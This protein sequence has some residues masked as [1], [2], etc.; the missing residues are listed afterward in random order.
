MAAGESSIRRPRPQ[1]RAAR[2]WRVRLAC[3]LSLAVATVA[4]LS[5]SNPLGPPN[6]VLISIDTLRADHLGAYGYSRP[7]SPNIDG[8]AR[9]GA[10]FENAYSPASWTLPAHASMM[11]GVSP[12]RHG[13]VSPTTRIRTDF[14]TLAERLKAGGYATAAAINAP[15]VSKRYGFDRGFDTFFEHYK[16]PRN[17]VLYHKRVLDL[18]A[19]QKKRPVFLFIH[20]MDV[21][22]PYRPPAAFNRFAS[23]EEG[24][25]EILHS[26]GLRGANLLEL[27]R[28]VESGKTALT[29][30]ER[31]T[32]VGLYDGEILSI[33]SKI[34]EVVAAIR[35]ELGDNTIIIVTA[36]HGEEFLEHGGLLH[37][38]TLYDEVLHV[39]LIV[40]GPGVKP[41]T[42]LKSMV[43]L[44][45][46]LPTVVEWT[47]IAT[48]SAV[49][50][51]SFLDLMRGR[52]SD[53]NRPNE[54]ALHTR[55][56][57]QSVDLRGLRL[58]NAKLIRDVRKKT[59]AS[60]DL[61]SDPGEHDPKKALP[62][63]SATELAGLE[64]ELNRLEV[65]AS[66]PPPPPDGDV[67]ESLRAL[68]YL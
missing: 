19:T 31:E 44:L 51:R 57:D 66:S 34:A 67:V 3:G 42:R 8:L 41:G 46:I 26:R 45:D 49:E 25:D 40:V 2:P 21:H 58:A 38:T 22:S 64:A 48:D 33:D 62:D 43:S 32:L 47:K 68:G 4:L 59:E 6:V 36:D 15:F 30:T 14:S 35:Q 17:P 20:Y 1:R 56:A 61:S 13:A 11:T 27:A 53:E 37:G 29:S 24:Q 50:G 65:A 28:A 9:A 52:E 12:Y 60:Y 16:R 55:A 18:I 5:C 63:L 54:L 7:T 10:L 39:P 23:G